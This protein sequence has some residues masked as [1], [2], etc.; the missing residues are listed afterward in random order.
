M[1]SLRW[2]LT[3][4]ARRHNIAH[5]CVVQRPN[6][7]EDFAGDE[8]R[9]NE[10]RAAAITIKS[11]RGAEFKSVSLWVKRQNSGARGAIIVIR[12]KSGLTARASGPRREPAARVE[13]GWNT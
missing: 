8:G 2:L 5:I 1:A 9:A 3:T 7:P 10:K 4:K 6:V 11:T 12:A 13:I